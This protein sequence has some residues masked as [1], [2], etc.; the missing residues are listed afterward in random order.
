M[1][2]WWLVYLYDLFTEFVDSL[3]HVVCLQTVMGVGATPGGDNSRYCLVDTVLID[4]MR[5]LAGQLTFVFLYEVAFHPG[6]ALDFAA[7]SLCYPL[8]LT[9]QLSFIYLNYTR[10][11][12][13]TPNTRLNSACTGLQIRPCIREFISHCTLYYK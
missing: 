4:F 9:G 1:W 5:V 3:S 12:S 2:L 11:E 13:L 7:P 10:S 8:I 6:G